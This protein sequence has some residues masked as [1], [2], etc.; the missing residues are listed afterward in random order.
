M[1]LYQVTATLTI[2]HQKRDVYG[3]RGIRWSDYTSDHQI[4]TFYLNA[5]VQG[6]LSEEGA[7]KVANDIIGAGREGRW[8][9]SITIRE[10]EREEYE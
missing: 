9:C 8:G 6:I 3:P 7:R 10:V 4:P 5:A 1:K 2:H